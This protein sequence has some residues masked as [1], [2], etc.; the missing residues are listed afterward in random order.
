M[1]ADK[2]VGSWTTG[3]KWNPVQTAQDASSILK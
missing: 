1:D 3:E 2:F